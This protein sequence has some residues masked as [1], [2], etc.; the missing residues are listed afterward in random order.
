MRP[1]FPGGRRSRRTPP[2][3][4]DV[5]GRGAL[6]QAP[7]GAGRAQHGGSGREFAAPVAAAAT[8][9]RDGG[10][11]GADGGRDGQEAF[12]RLGQQRHGRGPEPLS[13]LRGVDAHPGAHVSLPRLPPGDG[14]SWAAPGQ[15]PASTCCKPFPRVP[16]APLAQSPEPRH[17]R[18]ANFCCRMGHA[19]RPRYTPGLVREKDNCRPAEKVLWLGST[20]PVGVPK[21]GPSPGLR[22]P[23]HSFS[24][25]F[26]HWAN[27]C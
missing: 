15:P 7:A 23:L 22:R 5:T 12:Q 11:G 27:A 9:A 25:L 18:V 1:Q 26:I 24:T 16:L 8:P 3:G 6:E 2:P 17:L 4:S 14:E 21:R 10:S 19:S 13:L 20:G